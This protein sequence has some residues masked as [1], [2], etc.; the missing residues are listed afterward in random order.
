MAGLMIVVTVVAFNLLGDRLAAHFSVRA[1]ETFAV[2][3]LGGEAPHHGGPGMTT[4]L[5]IKALHV[6]PSST[7]P[8]R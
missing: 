5:E 7:V 6:E 2:V 1:R 4:L 3:A 8:G